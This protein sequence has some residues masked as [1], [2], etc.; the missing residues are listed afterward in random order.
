MNTHPTSLLDA[1]V[2]KVT[3]IVRAPS[4]AIKYPMANGQVIFFQSKPSLLTLVQVRRFQMRFTSNEDYYEAMKI[5]SRANVPTVEAGSFPTTKPQP[6]QPVLAPSNILPGDSA[7]QTSTSAQDQY[8]YLAR[9]TDYHSVGVQ[10]TQMPSLFA[11]RPSSGGS[12][13]MRPPTMLGGT[14]NTS[15]CRPNDPPARDLQTM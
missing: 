15:I 5:L 3:I 8:A 6:N 10:H 1:Q 2:P 12:N 13:A 14:T 11:H 7:S 4:I 9:N